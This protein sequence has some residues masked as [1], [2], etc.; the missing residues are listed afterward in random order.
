[1]RMEQE[2]V[3]GIGCARELD[4][5]GIQ[6]SVWHINE[7]HAAFL[8]LERARCA[9]KAMPYSEALENVAAN[10]V[11]TTHTPVAA[12][13]DQFDRSMIE[14][15]LD[16]YCRE[17]GLP[18]DDLLALGRHATEPSF[19]MTALAVRGA[20]FHNAVSWVRWG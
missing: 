10:T 3:H 2:L 4:A 14:R 8:I 9:A 5:L 1:M 7:G 6:P 16:G 18:V 12:G 17:S 19:N 20:R 15:Y 11:F 13:H